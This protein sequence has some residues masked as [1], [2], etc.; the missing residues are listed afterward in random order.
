M[1]FKAKGHLRLNGDRF[2]PG[3]QV[4]ITDA[5]LAAE[6][7]QAG[8]LEEISAANKPAGPI[9]VDAAL[10]DELALIRAER[11]HLV[12][13]VETI[14]DTLKRVSVPGGVVMLADAV[15]WL[16][17]DHLRQL[18]PPEPDP[19]ADPEA[20][21]GTGDEPGTKGDPEPDPKAEPA[22][23]RGKPGK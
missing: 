20:E 15:A 4:T 21:T 5:K 16:V 8:M 22:P 3:D 14:G 9:T 12:K 2:G 7:K 23:K 1:D 10:A 19:K 11:D 6:L 18:Q 17:D 13:V